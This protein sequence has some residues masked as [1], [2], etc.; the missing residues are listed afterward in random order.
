MDLLLK[1][2][3][4]KLDP[5]IAYGNKI[6]LFGSCFTELIDNALPEVKF[7]V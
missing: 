2:D 1:L 5:P 4:N 3:F 6:M 7:S